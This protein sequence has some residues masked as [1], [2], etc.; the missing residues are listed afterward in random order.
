M[1][2]DLQINTAFSTWSQ[3]REAARAAEASGFGAVW[4]WDHLSGT[5]MGGTT[6]ADCFSLLG[7][8]AATTNT[9]QIGSMVANVQNRH[10]AVLAN[11]AATVQNISG[12]RLL[13]GLGCGGGP[14][15][16]FTAEHRAASIDLLPTLAERHALLE[17]NLDGMERVW[18]A[19]RALEFA[20]FPL[21]C[22]IPPRI[23]GANSEPLARIAGH[24][25]DGINVRGTAIE[26]PGFLEIARELA[27]KRPFLTTV[28]LP[29]DDAHLQQDHPLRKTFNHVDR[30]LFVAPRPLAAEEI[31]RAARFLQL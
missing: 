3:T 7:A 29:L 31:E 14:R 12:G 22:A 8:L 26:A 16:P 21:P 1:I 15:S 20:G 13:L 28:W 23:V 18:D 25:A 24:R 9:I 19:D 17:H 27:G 2:F 5:T 11:S 4:V 6:M 10:A 30:I